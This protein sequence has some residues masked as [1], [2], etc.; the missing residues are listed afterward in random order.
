MA[1]FHFRIFNI[2]MSMKPN[3]SIYL[4][5][6]KIIYTMTAPNGQRKDV[7]WVGGGLEGI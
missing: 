7:A 3:N 2:K 5:L 6:H 4:K 1:N